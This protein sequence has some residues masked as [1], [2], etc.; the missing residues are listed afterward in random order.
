MSKRATIAFHYYQVSIANMANTCS[1]EAR[2]S[3][4]LFSY[5]SG[6]SLF[7]EDLR[8]QEHHMM[9]NVAALNQ[10]AEASIGKE[11]GKVMGIDKIGEGG[12]NGIFALMLE[13]GFELIAKI[14]YHIAVPKKIATASEAATLIF[15]LQVILVPKVYG[16]CMNADNPVGTEYILMEKVYRVSL[17]SKWSSMTEQ[18]IRKLAY[19]FAKMDE[20]LFE[21]TFSATGSLYFEKDVPREL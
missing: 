15:R 4:D 14:P 5:T 1:Q 9:L 16:Y 6:R 12:F 7:N 8:L 20:K 17:K 18:Q 21:T 11:H 13:D 19:D 3:H 10:A 2:E